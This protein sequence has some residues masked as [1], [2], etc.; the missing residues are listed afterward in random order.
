M[1]AEK[2]IRATEVARSLREVLNA[3]EYGRETFEVER[4]GRHI[5][6]IV[7]VGTGPLHGASWAEV[8]DALD[9]GPR[10]DAQFAADLEVLRASTG[11]LP[12][13]AW[14]QS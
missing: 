1:H 5:A 2:R 14:E 12:A 10:A 8:R 9:R 6:R 13:S 3:V 7:P 4:H 11:S